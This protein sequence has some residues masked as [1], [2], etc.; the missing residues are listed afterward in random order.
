[1]RVV[2]FQACQAT[3]RRPLLLP[4]VSR[5]F[6]TTHGL[7]TKQL[8]VAVYDTSASALRIRPGRVTVHPTTFDVVV[9]FLEPLSGTVVLC[10]ATGSGGTPNYT[11]PF[12]LTQLV[13][14]GQPAHGLN[15]NRIFVEVYDTSTPARRLIPGR[16][17][18]H[19]TFYDVI[20]TFDQNLSG[21]I[22]LNGSTTLRTFTAAMGATS[23]TSTA[24]TPT[25]RLLTA[26]I[27]GTSTTATARSLTPGVMN[28]QVFFPATPTFTLPGTT[29]GLGTAALVLAVYDASTPAVLIEPGSVTVH[30][31]SYDVT[32]TF[33]QAQ[34]GSVVL[35]A[36]APCPGLTGNVAVPFAGVNSV[37]IAGTLHRLG[38]AA[39]LVAVYDA[40][41]PAARI[42]PAQVTVHP[43]TFDVTVTFAQG[44]SGVVVLC[45]A[46]SLATPLANISVPF[47]GQTARHNSWYCPWA[48]DGKDCS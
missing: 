5:F 12:T 34:S 45:G 23:R 28:Q 42:A 15:T 4:R 26:Q 6:G 36:A 25:P 46:S 30:P 2:P 14:I 8:L 13:T 27:A 40:A 11:E 16:V 47:T 1:M 32:V 31:T 22:V 21:V 37:S 9:T 48:A 33:A 3:L 20:L 18:V 39:L 38:T 41:T 29:H 24:A 17:T 35:N 19:P 7:N 10:G 44:Q 43:S